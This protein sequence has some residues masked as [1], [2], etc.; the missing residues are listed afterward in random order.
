MNGPYVD[1]FSITLGNP[2]KHVWT[3]I[4][5]ASD[6]YNYAYANCP[7]AAITPGSDPP[8]FVSD[9]Y[10]CKSGNTGT[11]SAGE[12]Y[13]SNVL[14]DEYGCHHADNNCCINPDAPWFF[15]QFSRSMNEYLEARIC[16]IQ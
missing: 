6:A 10:Y 16:W 11:V 4:I 13:T 8:A 3:Y 7:C 5:G 15:R 14:W 1:G 9:H 2:R 12:F